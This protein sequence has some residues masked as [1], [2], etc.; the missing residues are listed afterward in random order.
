MTHRLNPEDVAKR[1]REAR[2]GDGRSERWLAEET[3][4]PYPTLRRKLNQRPDNLTLDEL[5]RITRALR[6]NVAELASEP[7]VA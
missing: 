7:A 1:I 3:G 2:E 5:I 6:L 4:I